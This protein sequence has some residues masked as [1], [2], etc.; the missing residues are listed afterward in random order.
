[1]DIKDSRGHGSLRFIDDSCG[2]VHILEDSPPFDMV[3]L[4]VAKYVGGGDIGR[5]SGHIWYY[6]SGSYFMHSLTQSSILS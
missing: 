3:C 6:I 2:K 1:M 4:A 5:E